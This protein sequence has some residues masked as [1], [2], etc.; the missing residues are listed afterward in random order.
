V[1]WQGDFQDKDKNRSIV[2]EAVADQS[3]WIWHAYFGM[4]GTNNDIFESPLSMHWE[5]L[6]LQSLRQ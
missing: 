3:L 6:F 4:P 1:A 2:L 5:G